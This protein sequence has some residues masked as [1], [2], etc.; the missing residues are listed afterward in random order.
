ME[1]V[2]RVSDRDE[3][4][5]QNGMDF[6]LWSS[7]K[8]SGT[9]GNGESWAYRRVSETGPDAQ[10][11]RR[12]WAWHRRGSNRSTGCRKCF[13]EDSSDWSARGEDKSDIELQQRSSIGSH[14]S[15]IMPLTI[16]W[17][18]ADHEQPSAESL[19]GR[20]TFSDGVNTFVEESV[21]LDSWIEALVRV[22]AEL[23]ATRAGVMTI[24]LLEES[25]PLEVQVRDEIPII[26]FRSNY[27]RADSWEEF[28]RSVV[29]AANAF[30]VRV[31]DLEGADDNKLL[32]RLK[33][34]LSSSVT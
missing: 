31:Q 14:S 29:D 19:L 34:Q 3:I 13:R 25:S 32:Q 21:Y 15:K 5:F 16:H 27:V 20:L 2:G 28:Q 26:S 1:V 30:L 24:D 8:M 23:S 12:N 10:C 22:S 11:Q 6:S 9:I 18:L 7:E 17:E 4:L 33:T